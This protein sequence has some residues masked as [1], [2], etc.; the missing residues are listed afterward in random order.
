M[1]NMAVHLM[2]VRKKLKKGL[3]NHAYSLLY[4][5]PVTSVIQ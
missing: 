1:A 4:Y 3:E 2:G 5:A